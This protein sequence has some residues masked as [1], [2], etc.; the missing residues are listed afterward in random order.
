MRRITRNVT[1]SA[2]IGT[3]N[4]VR[5]RCLGTLQLVRV[6]H[7]PQSARS[8]NELH[9]LAPFRIHVSPSRVAR[10]RIPARSDPAAGSEKNCTQSSS[11]LSMRGRCR[12]LNS[13][14]ACASITWPQIPKVIA[15]AYPKSGSSY[16]AAS[17]RKARSCAGER[18]CPP[19]SIGQVIPAY[20][21]SNNRALFGPFRVDLLARVLTAP[22]QVRG[23]RLCVRR[24]GCEVGRDPCR[25]PR[26]DT[27][28]CPPVP[29]PSRAVP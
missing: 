21:A 11:P 23:G 12:R 26:A 19:Y 10:V 29:S 5:P 24:L 15:L 20:P 2:L 22:T 7:S 8:A 1:P 9:T 25:A 18:P 16:S 27:P 28:G 14:D 17:S 3:P 13:S 4:Q 6:R